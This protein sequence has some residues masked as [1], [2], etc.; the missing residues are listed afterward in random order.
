M[1]VKMGV[2]KEPIKP[3]NESLNLKYSTK[4]FEQ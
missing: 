1:H 4:L 3:R 2:I